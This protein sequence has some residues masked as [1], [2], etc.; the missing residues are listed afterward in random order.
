MSR[1]TAELQEISWELI[2][3]ALT[4]GTMTLLNSPEKPIHLMP[5]DIVGIAKWLSTNKAR[6]PQL[7]PTAEDFELKK[8]TGGDDNADQKT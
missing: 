4:K 7:V 1:T 2:E 3:E 8:T 6:K 5:Q